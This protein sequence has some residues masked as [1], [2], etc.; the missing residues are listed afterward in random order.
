VVVEVFTT[1]DKNSCAMPA[2]LLGTA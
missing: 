2:P 1:R